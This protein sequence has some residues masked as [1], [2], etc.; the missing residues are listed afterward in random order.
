VPP[1]KVTVIPNGIDPDKMKN[2]L[3][4][5]W[6]RRKHDV[7]DG[8]V[9]LFVGRLVH[10]KG[11]QVLLDATPEIVSQR[12]DTT[13]IIAGAGYY[14]EELRKQAEDLGI[15]SRVRFFGLANDNDLIELDSMATVLVVPSLYEPFGIVALEGMAAKVPVV[16]SDSGGLIDFV[17]HTTTGITTFAG[18]KHSLAW[19]IMQILDNPKL[20]NEMCA[21]AHQRVLEEYTWS[22]IARRTHEVYEQAVK[23]AAAL[24]LN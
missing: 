18:D 16:T 23:D 4:P 11:I 3:D 10:E 13:L 1:E 21:S 14:E 2:S 9:L 15:A 24:T 12:H 19:G 6:V 20:A 22:A 8:P 7:G 5:V 17:E